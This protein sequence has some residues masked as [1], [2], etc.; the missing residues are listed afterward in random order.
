MI[1]GSAD[2]YSTLEKVSAACFSSSWMLSMGLTATDTTIKGFLIES[3]FSTPSFAFSIPQDHGGSG[4]TKITVGETP[5]G[6]Q[7]LQATSRHSGSVQSTLLNYIKVGIDAT[8]LLTG[9]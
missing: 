4:Q 5:T 9:V 1:A 3:N 8:N 2:V 7:L 6:L